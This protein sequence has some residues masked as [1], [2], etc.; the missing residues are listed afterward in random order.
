[1]SLALTKE[2]ATTLNTM[3]PAANSTKL[4]SVVS[5]LL[6]SAPVA[7]VGALIDLTTTAK[8]D[9]VSAINEVNAIALAAD[10]ATAVGNLTNLTTT[11]KSNVVA[12]V[13]EVDALAVAAYVRPGTGI[14]ATDMASAVQTDLTAAGTAVQPGALAA[15]ALKANVGHVGVTVI[16]GTAI[17]T[18][19]TYGTA[20][21][22]FAQLQ[23]GGPAS[24]VAVLVTPASGSVTLT[25]VNSTGAAVDCSTT[26]ATVS[27]W[28]V[29][30]A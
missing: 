27:Y 26:P 21:E 11:A 9:V 12:A 1:M 15:T 22:C 29:A 23:T 7:N 18:L 20:Y 6:E 24:A 28:V 19:P 13:N 16:G 10:P 17:V 30:T 5:Q 25:V 4:G 8:S 3:C 2:Q 14:P